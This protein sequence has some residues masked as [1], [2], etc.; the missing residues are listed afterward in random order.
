MTQGWGKVGSPRDSQNAKGKVPFGCPF[1][2][3]MGDLD[4]PPRGAWAQMPW[5]RRRPRIPLSPG[6]PRSDCVDTS[7]SR[8]AGV[9]GALAC[10]DSEFTVPGGGLGV[11]AVREPRSAKRF[12]PRAV[13]PVRSGDSEPETVT[14]WG[15]TK[16]PPKCTVIGRSG[17][18]HPS[19]S[20]I[21]V[22]YIVQPSLTSSIPQNQPIIDTPYPHIP[23]QPVP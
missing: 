5:F 19:Q 4:R 17:A 3:P 11:S 15:W 1:P 7:A 23:P 21:R 2:P 16:P 9:I 12:A 10:S 20:D 22:L 13:R 18:N 14:E 8:E 6:C